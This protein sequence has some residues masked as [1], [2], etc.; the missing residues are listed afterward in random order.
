MPIISKSKSKS[1]CTHPPTSIALRRTFRD[2]K[3]FWLTLVAATLFCAH[4]QRDPDR[5]SVRVAAVSIAIAAVVGW[6]VHMCSH[7]VDF[8]A[9]YTHIRDNSPTFT[10]IAHLVPPLDSL[11]EH[12]ICYYAD[13]H[14]KVHHDSAI[15]KDFVNLLTEFVQ[16]IFTQGLGLALWL[17]GSGGGSGT[18]LNYAAFVLYGLLYAT[19]HIV[20]Y[21][22]HPSM[23]H[24]QHHHNDR[25]N[26]GIDFLDV[27]FGTKYNLGDVEDVNHYATNMAAICIAFYFLMRYSTTHDNDTTN[28]WSDT[29]ITNLIL[30]PAPATV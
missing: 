8:A 10:R 21:G 23:C 13:F 15:N 30:G 11:I 4:I 2:N 16:N 20:N 27:L 22:I 1:K 3:R 24:E 7:S 29:P 28:T 12:G 18:H 9:T 19:V 14:H 26:L 17:R 25:T 6:L 5:R